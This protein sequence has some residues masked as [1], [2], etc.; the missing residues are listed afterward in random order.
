MDTIKVLLNIKKDFI[1]IGRSKKSAD[2]FNKIVEKKVFYGGLN[3]FLKK[4]PKNNL[5]FKF[6]RKLNTC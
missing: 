6:L 1:P 3:K 2:R 4:S 5:K